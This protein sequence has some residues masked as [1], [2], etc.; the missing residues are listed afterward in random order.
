MRLLLSML[1]AAAAA[2][3]SAQSFTLEEV[4]AAPFPSSLVAAPRGTVFAWVQNA[5][6]VRNI[7]VAEGPAFRARRLTAYAADD[8]QE[9]SD[10]Q[11][12]PD[13]MTLL[14][15]R[16]GP[17]NSR[18]EIPNPRGEPDP[19]ERAVYR[20]SLAGGA[21][22]RVVEGA[23][24]VV[25]PKGD[26][27]AYARGGAVWRLALGGDA[28]P[29]RLFSVRGNAG[30]LRWSPD[31]SRLAFVSSRGDH[32]FVGVFGVGDRS[33][34]FPD[35]SVDRDGNPVWSPDGRRLAYIRIPNMRRRL[36][37][38]PEREALPWSI[39]VVDVA[40]GQAREVW[41]ALPGRGSAFQGV[42]AENQ[43]LWAAGDLLVF[44]WERDGWLHLY[45][46]SAQGGDGGE[47]GEGGE[48]GKARLLTPG[49]FEVE[50][51]ALSSDRREIWYSSNQG[52]IDRRH[53]WRVAVGGGPPRAVTRGSGIE[54]SPVPSADGGAMAYFAS[55]AVT[56]AHARVLVG[57]DA[58]PLAPE[59]LPRAFPRDRLVVPEQVIYSAADGMRIHAQLF[60]PR[61]LR[62]GERRPAVIFF[63]GG[64]RRQMLLG[65]HYRS[66]YHNAYALN[67]YLASKGYVVLSVNYR[68]GTGYGLEFREALHYGAAGASEFQD[69]VGAGLYLRSRPEVD[70]D[71]IGLWGGSYGG[72]LTALG[73]ARASDL[74]AAGVDI[75]GVHDW[76]VVVRN[77]AP[78]YDAERRSEFARVAY[79]SSPMAHLD[80]WRSPV[81]VIHGDDDRNVPFSETVD[82][83][84]ELRRR[85]VEVE[86]LVFPD[87]VH[88]FLLHE[89][90]LRAYRAAVDFFD[91]RLARGAAAEGR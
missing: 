80:G 30:S 63:H 59:T 1:V 46:V 26:A 29:E 48:G 32:A 58:K 20:I 16:G 91:R 66:Y 22:E 2:P 6:G 64:S 87:E 61:D 25:S 15:V 53:L 11:F 67:Q 72:Y 33:V 62:P 14:F 47:G 78:G 42:V 71:R 82:L 12:T 86:Q 83:L 77:F 36:P 35:P 23:G 39:R 24:V 74:F 40:S 4:M 90:W 70:P 57:G 65:F 17:P 88:S 85:G 52:D 49:E 31:G 73:L 84:E 19:A 18:G 54:W 60:T 56:P 21:P 37:F 9:L 43:L 51:V 75:H 69:V 79:Q 50:D 5:E 28:K 45:A 13:G 7:W 76:N 10:L 38:E 34:R 41:R 44:P 81:L 68:S 55:D 27:I 3:L 8:G 89:S